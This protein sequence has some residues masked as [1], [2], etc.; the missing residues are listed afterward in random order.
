MASS[1]SNQAQEGYSQEATMAAITSYYEL[2]ARVHPDSVSSLKYPPPNGWPQIS[3]DS[4]SIL[5]RTDTFIALLRHI[6]Y[7]MSD[8]ITFMKAT[9]PKTT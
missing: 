8:H 9:T 4:F 5:G 3:R 7:F 2:L 6:P 1:S